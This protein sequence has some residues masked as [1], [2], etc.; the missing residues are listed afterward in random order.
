MPGMTPNFSLPYPCAGETIDPAIFCEFSDALDAALVTVNANADFVANRP[1]ARIDRGSGLNT[2][3]VGVATNVQF[4]TEVFDNDTMVDLGADNA[5]I[6]VVTPGVYWAQF[7]VGT[8]TT[9]TT[10]TRYRLTITQN[11][12]ANIGRKFIYST[13]DA[14][15]TANSIYGVLVCQAGDVI[16]GQY[17]WNGTGGPQVMN[18]GSLS[19]SFICDL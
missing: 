6:T 4:S 15:F 2:F 16:R 18:S 10:W 17:L 7:M 19:M 13:A 9:F 11:G 8:I 1:N 12:T 3:A 14:F 5:A